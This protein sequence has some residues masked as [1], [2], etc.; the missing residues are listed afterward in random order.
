MKLYVVRHG[1]TDMGIY[2]GVNFEDL[3][4]KIF[5]GYDS[6]LQYSKL[7]SMKSVYKR[8]TDFLDE[9][10]SKEINKNYSIGNAWRSCKSN[11]LVF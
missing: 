1:E 10:R 8:I 4:W 6:D 7:E 3:D 5:W 9:L 2:D 11:L